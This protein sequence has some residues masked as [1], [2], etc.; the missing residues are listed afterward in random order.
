MTQILTAIYENG[1]LRPL[2]PIALPEGQAIRLQIL[3]DESLRE[4]EKIRQQLITLGLVTPPAYAPASQPV[5]EA[6]WQEMTQR[7]SQMSQK[8]FNKPLSEIIIEE[9]G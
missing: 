5:P 7:L 1:V 9:R 3:T 4:L 6:V 2:E 8:S